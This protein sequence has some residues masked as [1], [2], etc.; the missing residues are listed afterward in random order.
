[1]LER[2]RGEAAPRLDRLAQPFMGWA[3][4]TLSWLSFALS[5]G[6]SVLLV[7]LRFFPPGSLWVPLL[8]FDIA[9][10][11]FVGGV[12]DALDGHVARKRGLASRRGD[13]LDHVLDRYADTVLLV[14]VTFSAWVNPL[15][16]LLALASLL[17]TSYMGTQAQAVTGQRAYGGLL[18]R[19]DRLVLLTLGCLAMSLLTGWDF[20]EKG[21][22]SIPLWFGSGSWVLGPLDLVMLYFI[23][24]S[25]AT[26]AYRAVATW[27]ALGSP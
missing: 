9:C 21:P 18:G 6:A 24:A 14:G 5:V 2:Y 25:Q 3:P 13:F 1:M 19:A 15:L 4:D 12:F 22:L 8:F 26:A 27:R 17:L 10:L 23:L 16:G 20:V 7:M 11:I